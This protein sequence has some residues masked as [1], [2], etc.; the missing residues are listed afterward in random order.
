MIDGVAEAARAIAAWPGYAP[1][2]ILDFPGIAKAF[3]IADFTIKDEGRRFDVES[4]KALGPPFALARVLARRL[5][6]ASGIAADEASVLAGHHRGQLA[7]TTVAGAS[8]GNHGRALAWAAAKAGCACTIFMAEHTGIERERNIARLGAAVRRVPGTYDDALEA[9]IAAAA[10]HGWVLIA[11]T[12]GDAHPDV[13][14]DTMRGYATI[15]LEIAA[16]TAGRPPTHLFLAAG[17]GA[18]AAGIA[19]GLAHLPA[20]ERPRIVVVEPAKADGL[21]RSAMAGTLAPATGDLRTVMDGLSVRWPSPHAWPIIGADADAFIAIP[22]EAAVLALALLAEGG[23]GDPPFETGETGV[24]AT[25]GALA[26]AATFVGRRAA[27]IDADS[28]I[29]ALA[30]E[31]VTD[32]GEFDRLLGRPG[33]PAG[34]ARGNRR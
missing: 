22:D 27:A 25:A 20:A 31:G 29:L 9:A 16:Q 33:E 14:I 8:S 18:M 17:S 4:F 3:G 21:R 5:A 15:G 11:E 6:E 10:E 28:R 13:P 23:C 24:A 1:T 12:S 7:G 2:P 30:C 26:A 32:R 34:A 19:A